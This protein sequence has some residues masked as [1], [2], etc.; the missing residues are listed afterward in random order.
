MSSCSQAKSAA[1]LVMLSPEHGARCPRPDATA[2]SAL[3]L[4]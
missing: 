3:A 4:R 2:E 1:E